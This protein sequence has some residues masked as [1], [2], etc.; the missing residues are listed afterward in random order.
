[1]GVLV[2]SNL[3]LLLCDIY[4]NLYGLAGVAEGAVETEC[5]LRLLGDVIGLAHEVVYELVGESI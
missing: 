3:L 2:V 5:V 4:S 1:M